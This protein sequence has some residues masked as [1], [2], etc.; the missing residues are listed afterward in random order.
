[1]LRPGKF[2]HDATGAYVSVFRRSFE[3]AAQDLLR[4]P[5]S[6]FSDQDDALATRGYVFF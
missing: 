6:E 4:D 3:K 2:F 5:R 1:M